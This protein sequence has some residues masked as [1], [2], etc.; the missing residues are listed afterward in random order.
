MRQIR[1]KALSSAFFIG[2]MPMICRDFSRKLW[3]SRKRI[4]NAAV[5]ACRVVTARIWFSSALVTLHRNFAR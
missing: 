3:G 1:K 2:Q 5:V 4:A